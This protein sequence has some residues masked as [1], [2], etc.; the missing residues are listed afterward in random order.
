M[1]TYYFNHVIT[2]KIIAHSDDNI[3]H[4]M[5]VESLVP[6]VKHYWIETETSIKHLSLHLIPIECYE[7][8][9]YFVFIKLL[10]TSP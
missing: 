2:N 3:D 7:D 4:R 1:K 5:M 8:Q 9:K 6:E 10:S